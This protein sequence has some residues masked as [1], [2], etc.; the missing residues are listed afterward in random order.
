MKKA[1][2]LV[3]GGAGFIGSHVNKLLQRS[4]YHTVVLDNLSRGHRSA[5]LKGDFIEGE[6]SNAAL[7][8]HIFTHQPISAV[9]HFAAYTDVGESVAEPLKYYTNNVSHTI[10]LLEAMRRHNVKA[11]VFSSSAAVFGVPQTPKVTEEHPKNPI[12]P[13]GHSKLKVENILHD[14]DRA[15]GIRSCCL[16]YFNAAGG[17][18]DGEIKYFKRRESNLI[19]LVLRSLQ[20]NGLITINGTDYA[21]PTGTCV[22]DYIHIADLATAHIVAMERLLNG[23]SSCS[24]NLGNGQGFSVR[25]VIDAVERVTGKTVR[26]KEGPRRPGDPPVL[27]A[28]ATK[29][30]QDLK[31]TPRYPSLEEIIA[32][33][34]KAMRDQV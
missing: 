23:G 28:D 20:E 15:H 33:A 26:V 4:G 18:P 6:M 8:D 21:T 5:V 19:P 16:R 1:T 12:N 7:L 11:L 25:Q 2:V 10:T 9:M 17:D 14:V 3:V 22:R 29:A 31:W 32:H 13:Y 34:W 24:Y 27:V 30:H